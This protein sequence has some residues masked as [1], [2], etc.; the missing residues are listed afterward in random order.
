M[1]RSRIINLHFIFVGAGHIGDWNELPGVII[2]IIIMFVP[3][4]LSGIDYIFE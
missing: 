4:G 2:I 1:T 3:S